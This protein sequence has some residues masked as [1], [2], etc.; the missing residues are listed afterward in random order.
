[1]VQDPVH[2]KLSFSVM[3]SLKLNKMQFIS[4]H[5][6][7]KSIKEDV[8]NAKESQKNLFDQR[9]LA[10][11]MLNIVEEDERRISYGKED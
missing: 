6:S 7:V 9:L 1:M 2:K 4:L 3:D 10:L 8:E 11:T 5:T